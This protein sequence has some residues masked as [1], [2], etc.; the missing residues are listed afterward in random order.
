MSKLSKSQLEATEAGTAKEKYKEDETKLLAKHY[1][2]RC[3]APHTV[4]SLSVVKKSSDVDSL[5]SELLV[6]CRSNNAHTLG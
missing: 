4:N 1:L 5:W 2:V 3:L 6:H